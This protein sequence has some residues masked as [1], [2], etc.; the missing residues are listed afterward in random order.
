MHY[1]IKIMNYRICSNYQIVTL[2]YN[3]KPLKL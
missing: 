1:L 2:L 3:F